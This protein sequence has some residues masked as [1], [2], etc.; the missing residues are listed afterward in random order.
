MT[1]TEIKLISHAYYIRNFALE[2]FKDKL[3]LHN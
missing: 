2:S 3:K 1:A